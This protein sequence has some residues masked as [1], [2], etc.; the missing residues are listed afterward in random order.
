LDLVLDFN[1]NKNPTAMRKMFGRKNNWKKLVCGTL[2]A[3]TNSFYAYDTHC[4]SIRKLTAKTASVS[5]P[6]VYLA[7]GD[8]TGIGIGA[9]HGGYVDRLF[10]RI[11][12]LHPGSRLVNLSVAAAATSDVLREQT[13]RIIDTT[14]NM[15]TIG[16][17]SNDLIQGVAVETFAFNLE[18]IILCLKKKTNASILLMN[19]PD[20]SLAPAIPSYMRDSGHPYILAYNRRIEEIASRYRLFLVDLYGSSA[21]FSRHAKFFSVD[22]IHPS[23]L[24]YEFWAKLLWPETKKMI[25]LIDLEYPV[26]SPRK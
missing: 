2:L 8:S 10:D 16:I 1:S 17:G 6:I 19:I 21:V 15:V 9:K 12:R 22:G 11:N 26:T 5:Q 23:D 3:L 20:I 18:Q 4:T 7:L 25:H 14:P 24:G 13:D